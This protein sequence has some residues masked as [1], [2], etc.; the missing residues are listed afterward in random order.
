LIRTDPLT[1]AKELTPAMAANIHQ[2]LA[3]AAAK[4]GDVSTAERAYGR[5]FELTAEVDSAV[6]T[7][8]DLLAV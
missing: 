8:M 3:R 6:E 2:R 5:M 4:A 1:G 7:T